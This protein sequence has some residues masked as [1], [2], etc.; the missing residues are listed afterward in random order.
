M[1]VGYRLGL[2]L[3]KSIQTQTYIN[4]HMNAM[5]CIHK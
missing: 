2:Y 5:Q 1:Y 4:T 3:R